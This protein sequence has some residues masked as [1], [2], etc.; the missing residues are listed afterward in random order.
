MIEELLAVDESSPTG[1]VW[2]ASPRARVKVGSPAL[3]TIGK[4]GYYH[5]SCGGKYYQAHRV[6]FYLTHGYWPK[7]VDHLDGNRLNNTPLNLRD[8][9]RAENMH[10]QKVV[11]GFIKDRGRFRARIHVDGKYISLGTYDTEQ[12]AHAAYLIGKKQYH[13]TAPERCYD[14]EGGLATSRKAPSD[15]AEATS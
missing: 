9:S 1:L 2:A 3:T 6:V 15:R 10:N 8:A 12:E 4:S 5:G 11:R 7:V 13:P 14:T